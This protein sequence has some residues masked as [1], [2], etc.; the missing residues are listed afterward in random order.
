VELL[1]EFTS[2]EWLDQWDG[3]IAAVMPKRPSHI[4]ELLAK[5]SLDQSDTRILLKM[6]Q[7]TWQIGGENLYCGFD[8]SFTREPTER[9]LKFYQ[10]A[11]LPMPDC[12]KVFQSSVLECG[13]W[14]KRRRAALYRGTEVTTPPR[15]VGST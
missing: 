6:L 11:G 5:D 4:R 10:Q 8:S 14:G 1:W 7:A 9:L 12:S 2:A 3:K 13:G 15:E